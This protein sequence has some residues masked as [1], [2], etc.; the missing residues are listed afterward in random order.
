MLAPGLHIGRMFYCLFFHGEG[1]N[2]AEDKEGFR[3][4][5]DIY[6][7]FRHFMQRWGIG[8]INC[9]IYLT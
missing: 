8:E 4:K 6:V 7:P 3:N 2:K 1:F 9:Q 5:V